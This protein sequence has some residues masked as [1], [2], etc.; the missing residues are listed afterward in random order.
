MKSKEESQEPLSTDVEELRAQIKKLQEEIRREK[1]RADLN[2]EIIN[3]AEKK[4]NI[5]I[6]KDN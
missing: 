3:V 5:K 2:E 4:F 6:R 1:I